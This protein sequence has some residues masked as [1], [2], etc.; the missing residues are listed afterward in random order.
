[1][2]WF[3][4]WT[5]VYTLIASVAA[6]FGTALLSGVVVQGHDGIWYLNH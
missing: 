1:M 3:L 6:S 2:G 5:N 4:T